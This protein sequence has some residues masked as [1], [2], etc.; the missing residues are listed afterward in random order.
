MPDDKD[1]CEEMKCP[2]GSSFSQETCSCKHDPSRCDL[3]CPDFMGLKLDEDLC[4]CV[5]TESCTLKA[6][7]A[8]HF[9]DSDICECVPINGECPYL[10]C[11]D[12]F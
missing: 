7:Q 2:P 11:D 6:C 10:D 9:V 8:G 5:P 12:S 4:E 1:K 3:K